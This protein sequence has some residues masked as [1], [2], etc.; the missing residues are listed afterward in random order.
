M[1]LLAVCVFFLAIFMLSHVVFYPHFSSVWTLSTGGD[2]D[3]LSSKGI[4]IVDHGVL[5]DTATV[6]LLY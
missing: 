3:D 1:L 5:C 2:I 4:F 6:F